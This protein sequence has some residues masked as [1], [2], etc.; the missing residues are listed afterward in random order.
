MVPCSAISVPSCVVVVVSVA[1]PPPPHWY[2]S[3]SAPALPP[4]PLGPPPF[5][6][7][8]QTGPPLHLVEVAWMIVVPSL[9]AS[10]LH[11]W[12]TSLELQRSTVRK[13]FGLRWAQPTLL[14]QPPPLPSSSGPLAFG[15]TQL[16]F[17]LSDSHGARYTATW[18]AGLA[19]R[20]PGALG[21]VDAAAASASRSH[22]PIGPAGWAALWGPRA[23]APPLQHPPGWC[24]GGAR[25]EG[26]AG[27]APLAPRSPLRASYP[28]FQTRSL[29]FN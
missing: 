13:P 5:T 9:W 22:R 10:T 28:S 18:S 19:E 29:S 12:Y 6:F 21:A 27:A 24:V 4:W 17:L 11:C 26:A 2:I 16:W 25:V 8:Q 23:A 20:P 3:I 1:A 15:S 7:T 14:T